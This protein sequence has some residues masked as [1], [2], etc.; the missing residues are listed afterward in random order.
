ME[1]NMSGDL[2]IG[3]SCLDTEEG[4][5]LM[6]GIDDRSFEMKIAHAISMAIDDHIEGEVGFEAQCNE[7]GQDMETHFHK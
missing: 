1:M 2:T 3:E 4:K 7:E 6:E 5:K